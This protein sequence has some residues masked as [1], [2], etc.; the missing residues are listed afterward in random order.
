MTPI[1]KLSLWLYVATATLFVSI[2]LLLH[3]PLRPLSE[4]HTLPNRDATTHSMS[5]SASTSQAI[6]IPKWRYYEN[7]YVSFEYPDDWNVCETSPAMIEL[8]PSCGDDR[9]LFEITVTPFS[10]ELWN[11]WVFEWGTTT[12]EGLPAVV[13]GHPEGKCDATANAC[14]YIYAEDVLVPS[15]DLNRAIFITSR[16]EASNEPTYHNLKE[17]YDN[18]YKRFVQTLQFGESF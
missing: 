17:T 3:F 14:S 1:S 12:Y 18:M 9:I 11:Q 6:A 15:S 16:V 13:S 5:P 7:D 10:F 4:S 8:S 2:A